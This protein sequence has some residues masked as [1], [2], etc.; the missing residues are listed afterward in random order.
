M[1]LVKQGFP[2]IIDDNDLAYFAFLQALISSV[3]AQAEG[4]VI[5]TPKAIVFRIT[6]SK[7]TLYDILLKT[8]KDANNAFGIKVIFSKSMTTSKSV[9]YRIEIKE[10]PN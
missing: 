10:A 6:P 5:K 2:Q 7:A 4:C 3:D 9:S 1:I 8:I